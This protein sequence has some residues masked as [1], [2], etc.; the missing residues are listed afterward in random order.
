MLRRWVVTFLVLY[1]S[2]SIASA[3]IEIPLQDR[4]ENMDEGY[5]MWASIETAARYQSVRKLYGLVRQRQEMPEKE[6]YDKSAS[7]YITKSNGPAIPVDAARMLKRLGVPY[8]TE[9]LLSAMKRGKPCVI[10]FYGYPKKGDRHAVTLTD[11]ND[12][13][14][15]FIDSN[16]TGWKC[17]LDRAVFDQF[18]TG[19][20]LVLGED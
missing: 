14:V 1:C 3:Q 5:C 13:T 4:V 6:V 8:N 17:S 19:F 7:K 15:S 12:K 20:T 18:W 9:L 10:S 16:C 2:V 11:Y